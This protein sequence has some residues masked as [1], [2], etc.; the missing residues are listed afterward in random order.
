[1]FSFDSF[2]LGNDSTKIDKNVYESEK[3]FSNISTFILKFR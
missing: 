2:E 1:M 3:V